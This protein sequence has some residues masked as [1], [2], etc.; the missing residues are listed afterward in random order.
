MRQ[1]VVGS[2]GDRRHWFP[3]G[4]RSQLGV[5]FFIEEFAGASDSIA[6]DGGVF[7]V[8]L[9]TFFQDDGAFKLRC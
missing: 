7:F 1:P 4:L 8:C 5:C 3:C 6:K 2:S 9:F